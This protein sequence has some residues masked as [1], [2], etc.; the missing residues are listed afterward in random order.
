[1]KPWRKENLNN[2]HVFPQARLSSQC[3]DHRRFTKEIKCQL[4]A[5]GRVKLYELKSLT[6]QFRARMK[7]HLTLREIWFRINNTSIKSQT[8]NRV[9]DKRKW[10]KAR[11]KVGNSDEVKW[12]SENRIRKLLLNGL[13]NNNL[14]RRISTTTSQLN[15]VERYVK[16]S[17]C[18]FSPVAPSR[19]SSHPRDFLLMFSFSQNPLICCSSVF[20]SSVCNKRLRNLESVETRLFTRYNVNWALW[21]FCVD[22]LN[23]WILRHSFIVRIFAGPA[24]HTRTQTGGYFDGCPIRA[25]HDY[26]NWQSECIYS[27]YFVFLCY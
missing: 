23:Q 17:D 15:H 10:W 8:E 21:T 25:L 14:L 22:V 11:R 24:E 12:K 9:A 4:F 1:M 19:V 20:R 2:F 6:L 7:F 13:D 18:V 27:V 3:S 26:Q 5:C 16:S